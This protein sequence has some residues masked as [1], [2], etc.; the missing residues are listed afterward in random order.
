MFDF[1]IFMGNLFWGQ[2]LKS[3]EQTM[4]KMVTSS[5]LILKKLSVN[6][7]TVY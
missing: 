3:S 1:Y 2:Q 7:L 6:L 4:R 5:Y